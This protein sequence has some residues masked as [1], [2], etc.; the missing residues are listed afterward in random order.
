MTEGDDHAR[1]HVIARISGQAHR[2]HRL[3]NAIT[4]HPRNRLRRW[5][6]VKDGSGAVLIDGTNLRTS[7]NHRDGGGSHLD[8]ALQDLGAFV[9]DILDARQLRGCHF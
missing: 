6:A 3:L 2:Q 8:G 7:G 5:G 1:Q 9:D 4:E